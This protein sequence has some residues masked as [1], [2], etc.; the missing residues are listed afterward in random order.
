MDYNATVPDF[1]RFII[2]RE[3]TRIAKEQGKPRPW[4]D[5]PI[6]GKYRF[7]NVRRNDD[8]VTKWLFKHWYPRFSKDEDYWFAAV[9]ARLLNLPESLEAVGSFVLP[10]QPKQ[11]VKVLQ[12]RAANGLKNFNAA[13]IVSTNGL[14]MDKAEYITFNVLNI[15][16]GDRER[17]RP[18]KGDTLDVYHRMLMSFDGL[19][20][21]IAAQVIGDLK[22]LKGKPLIKASD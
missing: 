13:Y 14:A 7:C 10:F 21:F 16:W 20:S 15:I 5:D 1:A 12:T 9:V 18:K 19:G 4:T 2:K 8:R 17:M 11:F 22:Y 3:A 6:I